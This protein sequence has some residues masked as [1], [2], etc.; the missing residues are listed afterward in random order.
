[1]YA[2]GLCWHQV[3]FLKEINWAEHEYMNGFYTSIAD[4]FVISFTLGSTADILETKLIGQNMN[5]WDGSIAD[6][7]VIFLLWGLQLTLS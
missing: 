7:F 4:V 1:M 2:E 3:D 5:I 6:V